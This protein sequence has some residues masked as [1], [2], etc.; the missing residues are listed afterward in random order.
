MSEQPKTSSTRTVKEQLYKAFRSLMSKK[1][2]ILLL[3]IFLIVAVG[4]SSLVIA[5]QV[6]YFTAAAKSI[7]LA[8]IIAS[9]ILSFVRGYRTMPDD[10]FTEFYRTFSRN[11]SFDELKDTLDLASSNQGNKA[12]IDAAIIQN[13]SKIKP[14]RLQATLNEYTVSSPLYREFRKLLLLSFALLAIS[15]VTLINFDNATRRLAAFW[16]NYEKPNPFNYVISPGNTTIEQGAPFRVSAEFS[17]NQVPS[18]VSLRIK[19]SVEEEFRTKGMEYSDSVFRSIPQDVNADLQYYVE[20]DGYKSEIFTADVQLRPRFSSLQATTVPPAYTGLDSTISTYPIS[21]LRPYEGSALKLSGKLNKPVSTLLLQSSGSSTNISVHADSTFTHK[22]PIRRPD[23]LR[24]HITDKN[25]LTNN[26]PFQLIIT[27]QADQ[28]PVVEIVEPKE[29]IRQ[30]NPKDVELLFRADDDFGLTA[31]SLHYELRRAYVDQPLTG[32]LPLRKPAKGGLESFIWKLDALELRPQDVVT[33]WI[34]IT[35]NDAIN[36]YKSSNS[37]KLTLTV[38]SL[39]DYFEEVGTK[40]DRIE[41]DLDEVSKAFEETRQQY[42]QFKE[43]MKNNPENVGFEERRQLEQ[44]QKQQ[45]EVQK[46]VDELNQKFEELKKELNADNML[47]EETQK[48]YDELEKLMKE[49]DDPVYRE[50]M[51]KLQEQLGQMNPEQLRDAME[52]LEFNE[53]LYRERLERTIELFKQLKLNSD[54]DKLAKAFEDMARK[55]EAPNEQSPEK[56][57]KQFQNTLEE[58][59]K[60]K[61]Q[62]DSLSNNASAKNEKALSEYQEEVK[63]ELEDISKKLQ[64]EQQE[65][66]S[67]QDGEKFEKA[68]DS[69]SSESSSQQRQQQYQKLAERTKSMMKSMGQQQM[70]VNIAGLRY[71]LYSLLNLSLEQEDLSLLASSTENRSQAYVGIARNQQ[72]VDGIFKTISDSLFQLSAEIPQLSNNISKKK[73]E[74]ERSLKQA[75]EQMSERNQSQ[76]SVASRQA[77]GGINDLSFMIANLLEQLQ[78][79]QNGGGGGGMSMQQMMDQLGETGEQQQRL[80]QMM[81]DIINDMQGERLTKD[82]ME[83]LNQIAKQQNEIRKQLQQLQQQGEMAGDKIGSELQRMIEDMED[84]I[85]DLRGGSTDPTL[86]KR[87]QNILSRLLQAEKALQE[88]DEEDKREGSAA[89]KYQRTSP[90]ELTLKE[91]EKEIQKRLTDPNFTQYSPDY[92]RLIERYFELLSKMNSREL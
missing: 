25:E 13:L 66:S 85:N 92:Q 39:V 24:F 89:E 49:I 77:L 86:I 41:T 83:R 48:A 68:D 78:N 70:N 75:L 37:Q 84:T 80:N 23:T 22:L 11:S 30:V 67:E 2:Y 42:E 20:M 6:F 21:Q 76:S 50:A 43:Q 71:V 87:Q 73:A 46:K 88:R 44:A 65:S 47:S 45:E 33:F 52:N 82:R 12:L 34:R 29:S 19:T 1:K 38:P 55:E 14:E 17:G 90:P 31:A 58:N 32:S 72:N 18:D 91:L 35:D 9:A 54:L 27:P 15:T 56:E 36:G 5:E 62:V 64:E 3:R 59:E 7:F 28:F 60:L 16:Q 4:L 8:F 81:Q 63:K 61:N 57:K 74:V 79:S 53:K 40:E 69:N 51:E 26:N 10:N